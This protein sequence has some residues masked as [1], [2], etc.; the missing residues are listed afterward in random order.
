M[1]LLTQLPRDSL[2]KENLNQLNLPN[3]M[4]DDSVIDDSKC[5]HEDIRQNRRYI[6]FVLRTLNQNRNKPFEILLKECVEVLRQCGRD[7][8]SIVDEDRN[9]C[10]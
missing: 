5:G 10:K 7:I 4:S 3:R 2:P 9:N 1:N 6:N 8:L